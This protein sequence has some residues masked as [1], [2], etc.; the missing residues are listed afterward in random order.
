MASPGLSRRAG[1]KIGMHLNIK[2]FW[3]PKEAV[4]LYW[5]GFEVRETGFNVFINDNGVGIYIGVST[6]GFLWRRWCNI[7]NHGVTIGYWRI[8]KDLWGRWG[9]LVGDG[10]VLFTV[11]VAFRVGT[12]PNE[13]SNQDFSLKQF[14]LIPNT[15]AVSTVLST[16]ALL[17]KRLRCPVA[18][19]P[20]EITITLLDKVDI[21]F[22]SNNIESASEKWYGVPWNTACAAMFLGIKAT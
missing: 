18:G 1:W 4:S 9:V 20:P 16:K 21:A 13:L 5:V 11:D 2:S 22:G 7:S 6:L 8:L 19:D 17:D 10:V 15:L 14:S 3:S 12:K